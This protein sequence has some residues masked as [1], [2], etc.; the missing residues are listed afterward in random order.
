SFCSP[1]ANPSKVGTA[2]SARLAITIQTLQRGRAS[3]HHQII[4][5]CNRSQA[6]VRAQKGSKVETTI[7][8]TPSHPFSLQQRPASFS[9]KVSDFYPP[10][11][12]GFAAE[13]ACP[14][15]SWTLH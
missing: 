5:R 4:H 12:G 7:F 11:H 6:E 9:R 14:V 15:I 10:A 1:C 8:A 3:A 13:V 2:R